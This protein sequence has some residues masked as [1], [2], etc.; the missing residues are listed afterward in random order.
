M[1]LYMAPLEEVTGYVYR[2]AYH[3]YFHQLDK[4]FAPFIA[5]KPNRGKL[6]NYKEKNDILPEHNQGLYLV[7]QILTNSSGDF[8]RTAKGLEEYGYKE[9]NL[10][11]GCPSRPVVNGG[12]GS[13]FLERREEL[14]HFLEEIFEKLDMK[15]SVKTRIGRY[16]PEEIAALMEIF[17]KYP[18]EELII[19]PRVQTDYYK[20]NPRLAEFSYAYE[21]KT[22]SLCYNG[23]VFTKD[24]YL[25]ILERFPQI[26]GVMIGRGILRDPG[27]VGRIMGEPEPSKEIWRAFLER[28]HDDF[29]RISINEE[30]ALFK[31]KEIWCYLR[32]SFADSDIWDKG[33]KRAQ[34]LREYEEVVK[35]LFE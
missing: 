27:L 1:K 10:N 2:N 22:Q 29:C 14:D 21:H 25:H 33:I 34:S 15:I 28:L 3:T 4:Y 20:G 5:A 24:D 31:L 18:L 9:I 19:H 30:K 17:N 35:N 11:L 6:F 7:P 12:R 23:D 26:S 13:G 8:I 16:E 32:Y